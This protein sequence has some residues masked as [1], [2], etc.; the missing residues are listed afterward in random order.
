MSTRRGVDAVVFDLDGTLLDSLPVVLDCY[1]ETI[2][3][4]GGPLY[5]A[6]EVLNSFHLGPAARML[7][8]LIGSPVGAEAV[9]RY[10][11]RLSARATGVTAYPGVA[12]VLERLH[13][14]VPLA[15]L[16]S[17]DTAAARMLLAA[18]ELE[19]FFDVVLGGDRVPR[20]KPAPDGLLMVCDTLG[21]EPKHAAYVGDGP[22]DMQAAQACGALALA[23]AWGHQF[24]SDRV[25][26]RILNH[27]A[28][29]LELV[30]A[31][32]SPLDA[33]GMG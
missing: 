16:T 5:S 14:W 1:R 4:M 13:G 7:S 29:L 3:E 2:E 23:A 22:A 33:G 26:D 24:R 20:S 32:R 30:G 19:A 27:P 17:A 18:T 6:Q 15:V 11:A 10:E 25:A 9:A 21:V 31:V 8:T 12:S 28:E